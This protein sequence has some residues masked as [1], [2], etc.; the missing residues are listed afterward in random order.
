MILTSS[1]F[2]S[3][4]FNTIC[5]K[6]WGGSLSLRAHPGQ[7]LPLQ[8]EMLLTFA[9]TEMLLERGRRELSPERWRVLPGGSRH[10]KESLQIRQLLWQ[11]QQ[12]RRG[13][14]FLVQKVM[15][16]F[17]GTTV[18]LRREAMCRSQ[19]PEA[20]RIFCLMSVWLCD[21]SINE[22]LK[23]HP[24]P[25]DHYG[26]ILTSTIRIQIYSRLMDHATD[27]NQ[28]SSFSVFLHKTE[29]SRFFKKVIKRYYST[30]ISWTKK[31]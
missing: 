26:S 29:R 4:W 9:D 22:N 7:G 3:T 30:D 18:I 2:F 23:P 1:L 31:S 16:L 24:F 25:W 28:S 21:G 8:P 20:D 6:T 14:S 13:W 17:L 12:V 15:S 19:E 5:Q 27:S 11:G 10:W